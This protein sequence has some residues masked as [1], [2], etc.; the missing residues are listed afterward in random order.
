MA[1]VFITS[2]EVAAEMTAVAPPLAPEPDSEWQ[3]AHIR[4]LWDCGRHDEARQCWQQ[5]ADAAKT[6]DL[7][8]KW[9]KEQQ[10]AWS[11][12]RAELEPPK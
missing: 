4:A 2:P 1:A 7:M 10:E 11:K 3:M 9:P 8:S 12:I 6:T 5:V